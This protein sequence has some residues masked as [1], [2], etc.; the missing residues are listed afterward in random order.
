MQSHTAHTKTASRRFHDVEA[1]LI[2]RLRNKEMSVLRKLDWWHWKAPPF[3]ETNEL[4]PC[5]P[6]ASIGR[7]K[8]KLNMGV[9]LGFRFVRK[10]GD[11]GA[12]VA[13]SMSAV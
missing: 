5:L 13:D 10:A 12:C 6:V 2:R 7:C 4:E 11:C 8:Q 9:A 1:E 3:A